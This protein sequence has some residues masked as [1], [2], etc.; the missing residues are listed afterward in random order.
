MRNLSAAI[1][2]RQRSEAEAEEAERGSLVARA[3]AADARLSELLHALRL[4][5]AAAAASDDHDA[6]RLAA[7][8]KSVSYSIYIPLI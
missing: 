2:H 1:A 3:L 5:A 4:A 7:A 6:L 8:L